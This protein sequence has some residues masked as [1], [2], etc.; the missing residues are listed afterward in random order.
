MLFTN[1]WY[2]PKTKMYARSRTDKPSR[3]SH[4]RTEETIAW[5][6]MNTTMEVSTWFHNF[7]FIPARLSFSFLLKTVGLLFGLHSYNPGGATP[8]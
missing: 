5:V 7:F 2:D 6:V 3:M 4:R 8:P 1:G